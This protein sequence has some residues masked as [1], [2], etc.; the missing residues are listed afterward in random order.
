VPSAM[1]VN[2]PLVTDWMDWPL[3]P[4][5]FQFVVEVPPNN[6]LISNEGFTTGTLAAVALSATVPVANNI[7]SREWCMI[8]DFIRCVSSIFV[9]KRKRRRDESARPVCVVLSQSGKL[10]QVRRPESGIGNWRLIP[11]GCRGLPK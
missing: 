3:F 4:R 8:M 2:Q 5:A 10:A 1:G 7:V 11:F 9:G 6:W